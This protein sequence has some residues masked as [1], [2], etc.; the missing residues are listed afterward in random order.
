MIDKPGFPALEVGQLHQ[1]T[2][3]FLFCRKISFV[4]KVRLDQD[5]NSLHNVEII[6]LDSSNLSRVVSKKP[7]FT[8]AEVQQDLGADSVVTQIRLEPKV[9]VGL[10][11]V[12]AAVL[13]RGRAKFVHEPDAS[14][15][16]SQIYDCTPALGGDQSHGVV[17]LVSAVAP[18][19]SEDVSSEALRV[20][21]HEDRLISLDLPFH[22]G[23]VQG[24]VHVV[25]VRDNLKLPAV[26]GGKPR[27]DRPAHESFLAQ[28]VG[29]DIGYG[30]NP[31][32][33]LPGKNLQVGPSRHRSVVLH[34]L[35]DDG[36]GFEA[37]ETRQIDGAL[38]LAGAHQDAAVAGS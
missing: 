32:A 16:L 35:T 21:T 26:P 5:R 38:R 10:H 36:G 28:S 15:L 4:L 6:A 13:E 27:L 9:F 14:S 19:A 23:D 8:N 30:H 1:V 3:L 17:E 33:V 20:D 11:G 22:Q 7:H 25:L 24:I 37:G 12:A 18:H 29:D 34:G 31:N 2:E